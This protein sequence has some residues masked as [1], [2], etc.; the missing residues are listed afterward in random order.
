MV[1]LSLP[2][3]VT[4]SFSKKKEPTQVTPV[5]RISNM[6]M[7][8]GRKGRGEHNFYATFWRCE[9]FLPWMTFCTQEISHGK[10]DSN[11]F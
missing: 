2:G 6:D 1:N 9:I 3:I 4:E 8:F 11:S 5:F 10:S 7:S